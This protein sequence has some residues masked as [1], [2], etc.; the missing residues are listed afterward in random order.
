MSWPCSTASTVP[1][2]SGRVC[3]SRS[4]PVGPKRAKV[5]YWSPRDTHGTGRPLCEI[6]RGPAAHRGDAFSI[7]C[8]KCC[9]LDRSHHLEDR[10]TRK[11]W[12]T[13]DSDRLCN[14]V[15]STW[16]RGRES[17]SHEVH[18][19]KGCGGAG[20]GCPFLIVARSAAHA[21]LPAH[22]GMTSTTRIRVGSTS[23]TRFC[24]TVY[25]MPLASGA[26][27]SASSGRK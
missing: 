1:P 17:A 22:G 9:N 11:G 23:T 27:A 25:L 15:L 6:R 20:W 8:A 2:R 24:A 3:A 7:R 19:S 14:L 4:A 16:Q 18:A 21:R 13:R 26:L 10:R 5:V 12:G